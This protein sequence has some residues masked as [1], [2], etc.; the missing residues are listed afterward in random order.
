MEA[1]GALFLGAG[2][3][4]LESLVDLLPWD[5]LSGLFCQRLGAQGIGD[6]VAVCV[7]GESAAGGW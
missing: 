6:Q 4:F 3:N 7:V 2:A 1:A 5:S